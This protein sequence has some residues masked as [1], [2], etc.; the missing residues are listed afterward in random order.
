[1]ASSKPTHQCQGNRHRQARVRATTAAGS[2]HPTTALSLAHLIVTLMYHTMR[3][4]PERSASLSR[5]SRSMAYRVNS[6][7]TIPWS[8]LGVQRI[9]AD[10]GAASLRVL[11]VAGV[12]L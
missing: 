12:T 3:W 5:S 8:L 6:R 1:M 7:P 2:G 10:L 4:R 9:S 11:Y